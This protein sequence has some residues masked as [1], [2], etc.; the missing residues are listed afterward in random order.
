MANCFSCGLVII[1]EFDEHEQE[2]NK[3]WTDIDDHEYCNQCFYE[4]YTVPFEKA[5]DNQSHNDKRVRARAE[6]KI[7]EMQAIWGTT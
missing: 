2:Y 1:P 7:K 6:K 3:P 5:V 4:L